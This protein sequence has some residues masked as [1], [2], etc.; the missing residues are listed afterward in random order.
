MGNM[1]I[2]LYQYPKNTAIELIGEWL[3]ILMGVVAALFGVWLAY[4]ALLSLDADWI[5]SLKH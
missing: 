5:D 4:H 1:K 2:S 3:L